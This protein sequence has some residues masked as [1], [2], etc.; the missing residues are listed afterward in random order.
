MPISW[1]SAGW[2]R[3]GVSA[4][5][6]D[7]CRR[8]GRI[9]PALRDLVAGGGAATGVVGGCLAD[10]DCQSPATP[11]RTGT[12]W[13][14]PVGVRGDPAASCAQQV[15]RAGHLGRPGCR[16]AWHPVVAGPGARCQRGGTHAVCAGDL[17][18]RGVGVC[19]ADSPHPVQE[20]GAGAGHRPDV[21]RRLEC[22]RR[23]LRLSPQHHAKHAGLAAGGLLPGGAGQLRNHL[24]DPADRCAD[25]PVCAPFHL[26]RHG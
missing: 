23:V 17:L 9:C 10:L 24:P 14:W 15:C 5:K 22:H 1:R 7:A 26:G 12:H 20:H 4:G 2:P 8:V 13:R 16:Q 21:W 25:L 11:G 6:P 3:A 19:A 18:R